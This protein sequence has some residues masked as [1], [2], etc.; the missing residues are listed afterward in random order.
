MCVV[1]QLTAFRT[2]SPSPVGCA[3]CRW[4]GADTP[5][6]PCQ[7]GLLPIM[8][9]TAFEAI[10]GLDEAAVPFSHCADR[11]TAKQRV[12]TSQASHARTVGTAARSAT[13][14]RVATQLAKGLQPH[15]ALHSEGFSQDGAHQGSQRRDTAVTTP[16]RLRQGR[17]QVSDASQGRV[18]P[19][20][21]A[22][23]A[24]D[25]AM[26]RPQ[27][28]AAAADDDALPGVNPSHLQR[29]LTGL[30]RIAMCAARPLSP[31]SRFAPP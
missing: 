12:D 23:A 25:S 29:A 5:G 17:A 13:H 3:D 26:K 1:T 21:G 19:A 16:A 30:V 8:D 7:L 2:S 15:A 24:A 10:L 31:P 18:G 28:A 4:L 6:R 11:G 22:T 9:V 27:A 14:S 20:D